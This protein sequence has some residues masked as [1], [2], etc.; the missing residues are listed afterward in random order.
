MTRMIGELVRSRF[1]V[2]VNGLRRPG[3]V[4]AAAVM[5]LIEAV[6]L[7]APAPA[8]PLLPSLDELTTR[9]VV[10]V[11]GAALAVGAFLVPFT[12]VR[13][14]LV[15]L[16][17]FRGYGFPSAHDGIA[18]GPSFRSGRVLA[19]VLVPITLIPLAAWSG[20]GAAVVVAVAPL[21]VLEGLLAVAP[22]R[23]C[24]GG[25]RH[26]LV[27]GFFV[28]TGGVLAFKLLLVVLAA[29]IAPISP[30]CSRARCGPRPSRSFS[31]SPR[32]ATRGRRGRARGD[33]GRRRSGGPRWRPSSATRPRRSE[34]SGFRDAPPPLAR[35]R[36]ERSCA[37]RAPAVAA[38]TAL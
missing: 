25:A 21:V 38:P 9:R 34:T 36:L 1:S 5:V 3:T 16:R 27:A 10:T 12:V 17:A 22:R 2:L 33:P 24:R 32:G 6:G 31:R 19:I 37:L 14:D 11:A 18:T 13:S 23:G 35:G 15:D 26:H 30:P 28:R 4:V 7:V 8:P 20:A 29:H